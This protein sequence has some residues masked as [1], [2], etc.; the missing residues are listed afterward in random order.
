MKCRGRAARRMGYLFRAGRC[1]AFSPRRFWRYLRSCFILSVRPSC[2]TL[3][4]Y[5]SRWTDGWYNQRH[6]LLLHH[7][8]GSSSSSFFPRFPHFGRCWKLSALRH[9][10]FRYAGR[11]LVSLFRQTPQTKFRVAQRSFQKRVM[12]R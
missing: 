7:H 3:T 9:R 4:R 8:G 2:P 12:K 11:F 6:Q 10:K 1:P 5:T